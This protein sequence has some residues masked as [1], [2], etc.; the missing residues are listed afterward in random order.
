LDR[1]VMFLWRQRYL[2]TD[3]HTFGDGDHTLVK[4]KTSNPYNLSGID[5]R[6]Q[7]VC[8]RS[9]TFPRPQPHTL[10][11]SKSM[12]PDGRVSYRE[13]VGRGGLEFTP[14]QKFPPQ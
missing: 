5:Y 9:A 6:T 13:G 10:T 14:K 7:N 4:T 8:Q 3:L 1:L 12:V 2:G 11:N